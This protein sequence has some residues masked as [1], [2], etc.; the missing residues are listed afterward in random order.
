MSVDKFKFV[1]PGVFIDEIDESV[2]PS[3]P[4]RMGPLVV[5]RFQKGPGLRPVKVNSFKEFVTLF[6][7]PA[8]GRA[9]SD[10][11]RTGEMT[12]PTYAAYAVKAWLRNNSPCTVY[13]VLGEQAS[14]ADSTQAAQAGW[15]TDKTFTNNSIADV[16]GA[17]G[18]FVMP[19]PDSYG[20]GTAATATITVAGA[21]TAGQTITI[22]DATG[23][24][25][26]Y[27][28][29]DTEDLTT[30]PPKFTRVSGGANAVATSIKACL[31]T[32]LGHGTA[33]AAG[34]GSITVSTPSDGAITL[35]QAPGVGG[36]R[37][38]TSNASNTTVSGFTGGIGHDVTGTLAAVWYLQEGALVLTGTAR[39]GSKQQGAGI[40]IKSNGKLEFTAKV[41]NASST[42]T[43][44]ATFNFNR[45]S[46]LFV[47]KVFN[48]DPTK[49]N[50]DIVPTTDTTLTYW[51]GETFESN[52]KNG[53]NSKLK[54]TGSLASD[55]SDFLGVVLA[56]DGTNDDTA[57]DV[58]WAKHQQASRA[59]TTGWFIS[60]DTRGA[61]TSSFNPIA[62][63][64]KLFKL[65]AL[66]SGEQANRDYKI[67]IA[68]VKVPTDNFNNY[69]SFTV[70]VRKGADTDNSPLT[71]ERFSGC[72]LDPT[73]VNYVSRKI[74]DRYYDYDST[75]KVIREHGDN[76]N[77]SSFVRVEVSTAVADGA[78]AGLNPYGVYGPAV[79]KTHLL[80]DQTT[81]TIIAAGSGS[82]NCL[83]TASMANLHQAGTVLWT[84][85][86]ISASIEFPTSRTRVSSSEGS[87]VLPKK[88][89]FGYQSTIKDTRRYDHTN[90]DLLRGMPVDLDPDADAASSNLQQYSWVFTLDD[91]EQS[92][93]DT[94]HSVWVS[95][96]R[97]T[98]NSWTAKSGSSF[99]LTGSGAGFSKFT[100]PMFG[101]TDGFDV[102]E[103][104]PLR[105][106]KIA[107]GA[108]ER[109]DAMYYSLKK[110]VDVVSDADFVEYDLLAMP[111]I[112]NTSLNTQLINACEDRADALAV[113]DLPGGYKPPHERNT[114]ETSADAQGSVDNAVTN[115]KDMNLNSSY[116]CTF[117]P[118]VKIRDNIS[119]AIL[120]VP[121]SVV[122]LGT[123]SSSQRKSAVWFAPAGFT[124]GGLSE[125]SAGLPVVGVR[126]RLTSADR[127]KLYDANINPIA[128]FPAEG[129][130]IFGQKT[131]QVTRSALDR[132]N[133]RRLLIFVK[134]E[135]SRMA[136]RVLF[137]Q[138]VRATWDRFTS[139]VVPFLEDVQAGLGLVDFRVVLDET[140]TTPDLVDRNVLYAKIFLKPARAIEFVALDF[141]ITIFLSAFDD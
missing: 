90:L 14:N 118:W 34:A 56:L 136:S 106:S 74:G 16:G 80:T 72:S 124:R 21:I 88:A 132:I 3:L 119:D 73:S 84:T 109:S 13:R 67:S 44:T 8:S 1:S 81:S 37:T 50:S 45:D 99:V 7:D 114:S 98:G 6:G 10:S 41:L 64:E 97:D 130:V 121:P 31:E 139:Q 18:L 111:G 26:V 101:G 24:S 123:F 52:V 128:S 141:I 43:K 79:P 61:T 76:E 125:G 36:N 129:I 46:E 2:I 35:T 4:E 137:D 59:A 40:S 82:A 105:N 19:N 53:E 60:Q 28:A 116:G 29:A 30:D 42:V 83:P 47:R 58:V 20:G 39:D 68:D 93:Q 91:I 38:I 112:T 100:S 33:S 134:K 62:H 48:A 11:W 107:S 5:G 86:S 95:G 77:R 126:Q 25:K 23:T 65:H 69:G 115:F 27:T 49:T 131:M 57:T 89:Y 94:T 138:N 122:A 140:T 32:A 78:A 54:I 135:I 96:S 104:D 66:D 85:S 75:N 87:L 55:T 103:Q 12:A 15:I 108:T 63:T 113:V 9:S 71:L 117:F 17:Y 133:V 70:E 102:T 110:A 120:Y 51:L 127:D 22:V 92:A